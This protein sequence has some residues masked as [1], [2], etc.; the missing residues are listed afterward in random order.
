LGLGGKLCI[1]PGQVGVV[2]EAFSPTDLEIAEAREVVEAYTTASAQGSGVAVA[3]G[4]LVDRPVLLR[5]RATL[6]RA[7]ASSEHSTPARSAGT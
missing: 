3:R 5:A 4:R 7:A 6:D 1:H 2:N